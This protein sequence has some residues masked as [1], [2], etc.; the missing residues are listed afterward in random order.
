VIKRVDVR[1]IGVCVCMVLGGALRAQIVFGRGM[2]A[3]GVVVVG[4]G[5]CHHLIAGQAAT[6]CAQAKALDQ[7]HWK[8]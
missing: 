4:P 1:G 5:F 6:A 8:L 7:A 2:A 3:H